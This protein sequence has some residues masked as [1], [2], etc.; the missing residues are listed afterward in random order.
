MIRMTWPMHCRKE[1]EVDGR[2][3]RLT[4]KERDTAAALL[5]SRPRPI[6]A[7]ELIERLY[8]NPNIEPE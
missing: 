4:E 2:V 1:I 8:P 5:L 7:N 6:T 3:I